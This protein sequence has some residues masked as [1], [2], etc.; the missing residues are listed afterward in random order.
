MKIPKSRPDDF[1]L[2]LK[3]IDFCLLNK[4]KSPKIDLSHGI[5]TLAVIIASI[6][7]NFNKKEEIVNYNF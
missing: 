5:E 1:V 6:E 7:S 3:H 2:E 4:L